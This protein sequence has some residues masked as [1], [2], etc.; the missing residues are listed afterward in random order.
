MQ[1]TQGK[2]S[3]IQFYLSIVVLTIPIYAIAF[4]ILESSLTHGIR[5]GMVLVVIWLGLAVLWGVLAVINGHRFRFG[6]RLLLFVVTLLCLIF[7]P[8]LKYFV[9]YFVEYRAITELR[10]A[11]GMVTT[12]LRDL[13]YCH[14]NGQ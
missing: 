6:T 12:V 11:G 8:G 14:R 1:V 3:R 9:P 10:K 13:C 7:G 5:A 2:T 4:V